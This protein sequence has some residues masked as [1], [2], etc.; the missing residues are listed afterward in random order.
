MNVGHVL[1][2]KLANDNSGKI[3]VSLAVTPDLKIPKGSAARVV[4]PDFI[5]AKAV[6]LE[7]TSQR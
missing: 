5:S 2:I 6:Q 1:D 3:V 4:S 7:F